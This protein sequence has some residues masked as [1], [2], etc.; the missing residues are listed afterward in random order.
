MASESHQNDRAAADAMHDS[1]ESVDLHTFRLPEFDVQRIGTVPGHLVDDVAV[2]IELG[3]AYLH[4][5]EI[6]KLS[7]GSVVTLESQATQTVD[8]YA[9]GALV[10]RGEL[11][12]LEERFCVRVTE[13]LFAGAKSRAA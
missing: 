1:V 2:R 6:S 9:A 5:D 13:V 3:R 4:S 7:E 12:T 11:Q 8:V 10:A